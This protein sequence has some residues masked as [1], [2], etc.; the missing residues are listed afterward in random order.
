[1]LFFHRFKKCEYGKFYGAVDPMTILLALSGF[2][3]DRTL[4]YRRRRA[5][6]ETEESRAM[7]EKAGLLA[8]RY[9][10]RV[11][12]AATDRAP[13]SFL[14]YRLMGYDTM[15]DEDLSHEIDEIRSGRKTIP[16]SAK[17]ILELL[18]AT[19]NTEE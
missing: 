3:E 16:E 2:D 6:I 11:P 12:D 15:S 5:A 4:E 1:M 8:A 9:K 10:A 7:A 14:Q 17:A 19:A 18:K 13:I